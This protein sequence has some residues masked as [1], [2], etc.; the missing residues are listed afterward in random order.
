V[1]LGLAL[2]LERFVDGDLSG[3]IDAETRGEDG[4]PLDLSARLLVI[5][6]SALGEDSPALSLIMAVMA[7]YL[8]SV[9]SAAPGQ[10]II[11]IEEG[12]HAVRLPGV[13]TVF[14][15]LAK[16]GRGIG[17]SM[18]TVFHHISDV[19]DGSDAMALIREAGIMHVYQQ[20]KTDDAQMC[21]DLFNF[22]AW[23]G[24]ELGMLDVGR[25]VLKVGTEAPQLV[26]HVRTELETWITDTDSGMQGR[27]VDT[28]PF[29]R[30]ASDSDKESA[31]P[32]AG[33]AA[34]A[35]VDAR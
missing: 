19:P 17:L 26:A 31:G 34:A 7:T 35:E 3:L 32:T 14:R 22:P 11:V 16:R 20:D 13:A 21:V 27:P 23:V 1:G 5:D 24:D 25:H 18:V 4:E 30:V 28:A 15:S 12:Y 8:S 9:W 6:T 29:S 33:I 10:R 2:D